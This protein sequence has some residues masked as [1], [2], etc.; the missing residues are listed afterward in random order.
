MRES[1]RALASS[2][3]DLCFAWSLLLS[4]CQ[5]PAPRT[6]S[7]YLSCSVS[8]RKACPLPAAGQQASVRTGH[9][10]W[11][12]SSSTAPANYLRRVLWPGASAV[13][14][15]L[16]ECIA[17]AP[18]H[19]CCEAAADFR[20]PVEY[21]K[22][23]GRRIAGERA[24]LRRRPPLRG[25]LARSARLDLANFAS[26]ELETLPQVSAYEEVTMPLLALVSSKSRSPQR[27]SEHARGHN[28]P[29][30]AS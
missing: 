10:A 21:T 12:T 5:A 11:R 27:D 26:G 29:G 25:S 19:R 14:P 3:R 20:T 28:G 24:L 15:E 16:V 17:K 1:E 18:L 2:H 6:P 30:T 22:A 13:N 9:A 4:T 8:L 23:R 7:R